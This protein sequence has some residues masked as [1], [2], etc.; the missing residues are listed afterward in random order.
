MVA[1]IAEIELPL[2]QWQELIPIFLENVQSDDAV[3]KVAT[4]QAIG[5][6]CEQT[7]SPF[8]PS[9]FLSSQQVADLFSP[10]FFKEPRSSGRSVRSH[11]DCSCC[12]G[13]KGRTE[14]S[15]ASLLIETGC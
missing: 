4:L 7:V 14:V 13:S 15:N 10:P 11:I 2:G 12:C 8:F 9:R 1:A 6:V 5:F 3:L